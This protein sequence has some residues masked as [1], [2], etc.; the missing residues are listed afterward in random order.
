MSSNYR[1]VENDYLNATLSPPMTKL[2]KG[3]LTFRLATWKRA[4]S[5]RGVEMPQDATLPYFRA[6]ALLFDYGIES[7]K[8]N[9]DRVVSWGTT[10]ISIQA[11]M[12]AELP[13]NNLLDFER[14][15]QSICTCLDKLLQH[16]R[17]VQ[18]NSTAKACADK[19]IPKQ[20]LLPLAPT[21]KVASVPAGKLSCH[22]VFLLLT[23]L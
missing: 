16:F 20:V 2:Y 15:S 6:A 18:S 7:S 12:Q 17:S 1:R 10:R 21:T 19:V 11:A 5:L 23:R 22:N 4:C 9:C 8:E 3:A 14:Q 13:S